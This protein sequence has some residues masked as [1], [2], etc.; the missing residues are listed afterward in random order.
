MKASLRLKRAWYRR[1]TE[2]EPLLDCWARCCPSPRSDWRDVEFLAVDTET[3]SLSAAEGEMLSI[4][5][6]I[7]SRAAIRLDSAEHYFLTSE[8]SVGQSAT[9]HQIRDCELVAGL[10]HPA[11]MERFLAAVTG[12]V[13]VFHHAMLDMAFLDQIS[14]KLYGVPLLLPCLDTLALEQRTMAR[15]G[16]IPPKNGLRLA[17]C[18]QRYNLP[19]Y[20]A[21]NA[22]V[23][24]L[25]A[26]E[27][28]IAQLSH[29]SGKGKLTLGDLF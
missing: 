22:L 26:A 23:D 27:L 9:I 19:D 17:N 16:K 2:S 4:G 8:N 6:V 20:P 10:D 18:R 11:M 14:N 7:V 15:R 21:H 5:W 13:L 28:L 12:R 29:R 1:K 25:A 3:S 24:A